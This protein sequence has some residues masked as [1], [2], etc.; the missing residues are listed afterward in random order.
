MLPS[1]FQGKGCEQQTEPQ[2]TT[3][4]DQLLHNDQGNRKRS[5]T[6]MTWR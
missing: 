2:G 4:R 1:S 6:P 5:K 3:Q